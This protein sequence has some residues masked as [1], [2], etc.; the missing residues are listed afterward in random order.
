MAGISRRLARECAMKNIYA[1]CIS[2]SDNPGDFFELNCAEHELASDDFSYELYMKT[3]LHLDDID[4]LIEE[5]STG[6]KKERISKVL[7]SIIR[8]CV[9]EFLYFD[10]IPAQVSMNEAIEL[11]KKYEDEDSPAYVNGVVNAIYKGLKK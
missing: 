4:K 9:C 7:L 1:Y 6:W 8:L 5:N 11:S 3:I 10:D 2:G